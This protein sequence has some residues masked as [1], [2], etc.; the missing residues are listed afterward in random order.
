CRPG[1]RKVVGRV[2]V[3][4]ASKAL[5]VANCRFLTRNTDRQIV[6]MDAG[7]ADV[8][9]CVF[10]LAPNYKTTTG[11]GYGVA[12]IAPAAGTHL[13]MDNSLATTQLTTTWVVGDPREGSIRLT[14]NTFRTRWQ[15]LLFMAMDRDNG[16]FAGADWPAK[17]LRVEATDNLFHGG[18]VFNFS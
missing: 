1:D 2:Y 9:N 14:H 11:E 16:K 5:H 8:R 7:R 6:C 18:S 13:V 17:A 10:L 4:R 3:L 12:A 15:A